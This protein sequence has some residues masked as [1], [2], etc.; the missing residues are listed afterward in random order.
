MISFRVEGLIQRQKKK[1]KLCF[2]KM[3]SMGIR[4]AEE[5]GGDDGER[6][7][8]VLSSDCE[9]QVREAFLEKDAS[10]G[11]TVRWNQALVL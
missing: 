3:T 7:G 9:W 1:K 4:G 6:L 11:R 8:R 5:G 2:I 10:G